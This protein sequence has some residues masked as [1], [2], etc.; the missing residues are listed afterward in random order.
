ML[1]WGGSATVADEPNIPVRA[2]FLTGSTW[3]DGQAEVSAYESERVIYGKVREFET[4]M[5]VVKET[6]GKVS[7]VKQD[8]PHSMDPPI[9]GMKL[10]LVQRI[11]TE[12]YPYHYLVN[13]LMKRSEP[14]GIFKQSVSSQEWCGTTF[15]QINHMGGAW[16]YWW[17]SYWQGE[18]HGFRIFSLAPNTEESLLLSLRSVEWSKGVEFDIPVVWRMHK[19][20]A[21]ATDPIA[22]TVSCVERSEVAGPKGKTSCWKIVARAEQQGKSYQATYWVADAAPYLLLRFEGSEG[23]KLQLKSSSRRIYW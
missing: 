21:V 5:I 6:L 7:R 4:T 9:D 22:T 19:N 2:G 11:E 3:E 13:V 20:R 23:R 17:D 14:F 1:G 12:N 15:Q 18:A 16:K 8:T 10:N